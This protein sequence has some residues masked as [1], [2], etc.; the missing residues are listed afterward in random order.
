[1]IT[2]NRSFPG[3]PETEDGIQLNIYCIQVRPYKLSVMYPGK[4]SGSVIQNTM[5]KYL[6]E[7]SVRL[8]PDDKK[9]SAS[10]AGTCQQ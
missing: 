7:P 9:M 3:N 5:E 4:P 6:S 1:M 8:Q 2:E 10:P